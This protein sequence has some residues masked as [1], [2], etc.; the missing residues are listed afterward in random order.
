MRRLILC[1]TLVFSLHTAVLASTFKWVTVGKGPDFIAV[2]PK[3]NL[4]YSSNTGDGTNDGTVSVIDGSTNTVTATIAVGGE[5][6]GIAVNPVTNRIY[7]ALFAGLQSTVSVIDGSSNAVIAN[8]DDPGAT[9][10]VADALRNRIYT[11][12]SDN[13]VRAID[14]GDNSVFGT[15]PFSSVLEEIAIDVA[16]NLVYVN[17]SSSS[18]GVAVISGSTSEV[19]STIS[20]PQASFLAGLA[21]DSSLNQIYASDSLQGVLYVISGATGSVSSAVTL[22]GSG[23][24][25]F[26]TIGTNHQILVSNPGNGEVFLINPSTLKLSRSI[27]LKAGPWGIAVNPSTRIMYVGLSLARTVAVVGP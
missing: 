15:I 23:N 11:S 14:C 7:V 19:I 8:I 4:I 10:V 2:N 3:T 21:V 16:R 12:N 27:F 24:A 25:K 13:T 1:C 9:F 17:V 20:V 6:Q 18:P 5:P 26:V 22:T